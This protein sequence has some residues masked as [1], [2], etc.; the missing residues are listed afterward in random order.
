MFKYHRKQFTLDYIKQTGIRISSGQ[1]MYLLIL[2]K[3]G[4]KTE[5]AAFVGDLLSGF[6]RYK[7][8]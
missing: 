5:S 6:R 7:Q 2:R 1:N 8:R 3:N 4:I